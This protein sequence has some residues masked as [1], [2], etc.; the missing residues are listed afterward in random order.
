VALDPM[1]A[2]RGG[3]MT[4]LDPAMGCAC[5]TTLAAGET[6]APMD[7]SVRFVRTIRPASGTVSGAAREAEAVFRATGRIVSRGGCDAVREGRH[8]GPDG[9][10]HAVAIS[11][12]LICAK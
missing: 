10:L 12:C 3:A 5:H 2:V 8:E 4:L 7:A 9:R 1:G 6:C 11:S